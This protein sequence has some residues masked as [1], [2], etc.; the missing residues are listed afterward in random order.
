MA[1]SVLE[2][3]IIS[4]PPPPP[5]PPPTSDPPPSTSRNK[6]CLLPLIE[7]PNTGTMVSVVKSEAQPSS[8][9]N[10]FLPTDLLLALQRQDN[11]NLQT[12][13]QGTRPTSLYQY[14]GESDEGGSQ[15]S[16]KGPARLWSNSTR[17]N[18]LKHLTNAPP[19]ICGAGKD[20]SFLYD[21]VPKERK[22]ATRKVIYAFTHTHFRVHWLV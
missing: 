10:N 5:P 4:D 2:I 12:P 18:R 20:I 3:N 1:A 7:S 21:S 11:V 9:N 13:R 6:K 14:G 22:T 15:K 16:I 17:R 19:C 8:T